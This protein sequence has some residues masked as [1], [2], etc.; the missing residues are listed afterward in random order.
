M[1]GGGI[2]GIW[3]A[4]Q[5]RI[6]WV[7]DRQRNWYGGSSSRGWEDS[8]ESWLKSSS[9]AEL[10][11]REEERESSRGGVIVEEE[12]E[13]R[14]EAREGSRQQTKETDEERDGE[15]V[16]MVVNKERGAK[17][18]RKWLLPVAVD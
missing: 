9:V 2:D 7:R 1:R 8:R 14:R 10:G 17:R 5:Q 6:R 3:V 4:E 18:G 16:R 13:G 12:E 11:I 15:G